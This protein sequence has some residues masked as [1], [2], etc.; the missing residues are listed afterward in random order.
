MT[1]AQIDLSTNISGF[2]PVVMFEGILNFL[3]PP[4]ASRQGGLISLGLSLAGQNS[5]FLRHAICHPGLAQ[6][7]ADSF[8]DA[9]HNTH[10]SSVTAHDLEF[11]DV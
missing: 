10:R 11:P 8:L 7:L 1:S 4:Q 3:T 2:K 5:G 6:G 9:G